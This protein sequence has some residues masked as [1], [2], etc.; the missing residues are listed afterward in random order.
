[1]YITYKQLHKINFPI[2]VLPSN[3]WYV[4]DNVLFLNDLVLDE[5]NMPGETIGIRRLQSRRKD[6]FKLRRIIFNV[7]DLVKSNKKHFIDSHGKAFTYERK[8]SSKLKTYRIKR[9][10]RKETA[11]LLWLYE[12]PNPITIPRPPDQGT[13][14]VRI[15]HIGDSPWLFYDYVGECLKPTYRRV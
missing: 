8:Y 5:R 15:L 1:M 10:Q 12:V 11:S 3:E 9:I 14:F 6:L 4:K 2:Y 7:E 13:S